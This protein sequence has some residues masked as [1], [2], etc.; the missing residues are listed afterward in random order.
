[1][2]HPIQPQWP[3]RY[4][5]NTTNG[6]TQYHRYDQANMQTIQPKEAPNTTAMTSRYADNTTKGSTKYH[7]YDQPICRQYDQ[8]KHLI[9]PMEAPNTQLWPRRES[10]KTQKMDSPT[11]RQARTAASYTREN[12]I[13]MQSYLVKN[14]TT[15]SLHYFHFHP[16]ISPKLNS[17]LTS[18]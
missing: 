11:R 18:H 6:S 4:A 16:K 7:S 9:Q 15:H 5:V 12:T 3:S 13:T 8:K 10:R 17:R 2:K 14:Q 1:M